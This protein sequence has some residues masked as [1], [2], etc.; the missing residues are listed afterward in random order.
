MSKEIVFKPTDEKMESYRSKQ[1]DSF[2][3]TIDTLKNELL[4]YCLKNDEKGARNKQFF[5]YSSLQYITYKVME[6]ERNTAYNRYKEDENNELYFL[7]IPRIMDR[8]GLLQ[9]TTKRLLLLTEVVVTPDYFD[10]YDKFTKKEEEI[11]KIIDNF[12]DEMIDYSIGEI[13][14]DLDEFKVE[15]NDEMTI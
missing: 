5:I 3:N 11:T 14:N 15:N 10:E 8:E 4:C 2:L 9:C 1:T 7:T 6:D 12:I 13:I